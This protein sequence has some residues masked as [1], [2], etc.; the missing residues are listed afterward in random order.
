MQYV[1]LTLCCL[2]G[3]ILGVIVSKPKTVGIL[4]VDYS[5]PDDGPYLSLALKKDGL[6]T[7]QSSDYVNL[8][9]TVIDSHN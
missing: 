9:V 5:D 4:R 8:K 6:E 1:M 2:I 7:I 3:F